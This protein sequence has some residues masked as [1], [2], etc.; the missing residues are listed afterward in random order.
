MKGLTEAERELR[1]TAKRFTKAADMLGRLGGRT[2]TIRKPKVKRKISAA[3]LKRIRL[4][5]QKRWA[6]YRKQHV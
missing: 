6:K 2:K 5:Q 1:V 4:A 3:G